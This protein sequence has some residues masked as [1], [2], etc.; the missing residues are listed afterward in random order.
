MSQ[1]ASM[2]S[3]PLADEAG[4]PIR[5]R[6]AVRG[7]PA[8]TS[9]RPELHSHRS[10][11]GERRESQFRPLTFDTDLGRS[12]SARLQNEAGDAVGRQVRVTVLETGRPDTPAG[13]PGTGP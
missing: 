9:R 5:L 4:R 10:T 6:R 11:E 13:L 8:L 2:T 3:S 1:P 12:T 7:A